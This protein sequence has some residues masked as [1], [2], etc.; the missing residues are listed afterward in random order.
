[1]GEKTAT[2]V[3]DPKSDVLELSAILPE[4]ARVVFTSGGLEREL[5][6]NNAD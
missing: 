2:P 6:K 1:M 4:A 3:L 5:E